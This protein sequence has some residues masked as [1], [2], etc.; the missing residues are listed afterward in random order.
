MAPVL[1]AEDRTRVAA[2]C[3]TVKGYSTE[4]HY[5]FFRHLLTYTRTARMLMLGVYYGRDIVFLLDLAARLQKPLSITGVD[6]FSD[7]FCEDWP[8]ERRSLN[9]QAA[10]FGAAPTLDA[11]KSNIARFGQAELIKER[12]A[13][14]LARCKDKFDAIYLDTSHDYETVCR[15]I[16]QALP[17]L[18]SEGL[19]MGDDYSDQGTW[20]VRRALSELAPGHVV[21]GNWIWI[22]DT[23]LILAQL[24]QSA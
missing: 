7:D 12:D 24:P 5:A 10:G 17:L 18:A 2:I 21:F 19:L 20:G 23:S 16:R 6:K 1:T 8:V 3:E 4:K 13:Y 14:F 9:W 11:A 22:A 15:Q